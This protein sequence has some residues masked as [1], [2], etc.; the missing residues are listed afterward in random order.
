MRWALLLFALLEW[1][2]ALTGRS[3]LS[4]FVSEMYSFF[5]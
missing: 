3:D 1:T 5:V 2:D 4:W